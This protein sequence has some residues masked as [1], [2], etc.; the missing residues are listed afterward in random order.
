MTRCRLSRRRCARSAAFAPPRRA[1]SSA[2]F[3]SA[4]LPKCVA[5]ALPCAWASLV[6]ALRRFICAC[7]AWPRPAASSLRGTTAPASSSPKALRTCASSSLTPACPPAAPSPAPM[8][9]LPRRREVR[10]NFRSQSAAR[11]CLKACSL[12]AT[13]ASAAWTRCPRQSSNQSTCSCPA[14]ARRSAM[15]RDHA[16]S[17]SQNS[18]C[19][20]CAK[21]KRCTMFSESCASCALQTSSSA[22]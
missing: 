4:R 15:R 10:R 11:S 6:A 2:L 17:A 3:F 16:H 20:S 21:E 18:G 12:A 5:A 13:S 19:G 1:L 22:C 8:A 14:C 7:S 9:T